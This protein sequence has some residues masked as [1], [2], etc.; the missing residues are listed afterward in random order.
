MNWPRISAGSAR[1]ISEEEEEGS[2]AAQVCEALE[3]VE[4]EVARRL[5]SGAVVEVEL[6][7]RTVPS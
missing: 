4:E 3:E 6:N 2:Q 1:A 5:Y 7:M